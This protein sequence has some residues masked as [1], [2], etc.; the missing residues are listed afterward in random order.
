MPPKADWCLG[1]IF[2]FNPRYFS[3]C[4]V[5]ASVFLSPAGVQLSWAPRPSEGV[6]ASVRKAEKQKSP[7]ALS[8]LRPA[9]CRAISE[10]THNQNLTETTPGSATA[11]ISEKSCLFNGPNI[12]QYRDKDFYFPN[13]LSEWLLELFRKEIEVWVGKWAD[14]D[15]TAMSG[16]PVT[17]P[18]Q[19]PEL[20][21]LTKISLISKRTHGSRIRY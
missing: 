5:G 9:I 8:R 13:Y 10:L 17:E 15:G 4:P 2:S 11:L 1:S 18:E 7:P 20:H 16:Q 6:F 19:A 21:P 14:P 3:N 12:V